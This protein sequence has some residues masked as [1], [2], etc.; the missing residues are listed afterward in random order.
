MS[1]LAHRVL[2]HRVARSALAADSSTAPLPDF[3]GWFDERNRADTSRI[4]RIPFASLRGWNFQSGT[5]NLVHDSGR[6]FSIEGLDIRM[7]G[8]AVDAWTQPILHQPEVGILGIIAKEFN[9]ILHFLMQA[10][11]EP[12]NCN[13][14]Q[15]SPTVQ[16]TRSNYTRVHKGAAVPYVEYFQRLGQYRIL[17]DVRQSEQGC[18]FYRKRNRNVVIE[19]H[20]D[21]EV[22]D[23][24]RWLTLGQLHQLLAV[25]DL[26]NMDSRSVLAC[27]PFPFH[28][29]GTSGAGHH[30]ALIGTDLLS[31]ITEARTRCDPRVERLPLD[32]VRHWQRSA[33]RISHESGRF[34]S[35][36]AV[37]VQAGGR[38][39]RSWS[40]P[41]I[42]PHGTGVSALLTRRVDGVL[43]A[44]VHARPE[45]GCTDALEL[46]PTVQCTP[47]NYTHLP[48]AA[49]PP[50]LDQVIEAAPE[51][52]LFDSV[53]SEEGGRFYHAR[54][55][56][57]VLDADPDLSN[58]DLG[59]DYRWVP[60]PELIGLIRHSHYLNIEA[61]T[62][63]TCLQSLD[64]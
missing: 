16:A 31:W 3:H 20:E 13:G 23:G 59:P 1:A 40:Q 22:L 42:E 27:L 61:R 14:L 19:V 52:V 39:V 47:A 35:V 44:L 8:R 29:A 32:R 46:A 53:L 12:G 60:V 49:R 48:A 10:K 5:G 37:D 43:R 58:V 41:M 55:R 34:F 2:A 63:I 33:D 50:L 51:Q 38:E 56:Y 7:P 62:L 17:A 64:V 15:L 36:I 57:L 24:F 6:F 25:D 28:G 26:V 30:S 11:M 18:W 45:P 4:E 54:N 9:G 21:I